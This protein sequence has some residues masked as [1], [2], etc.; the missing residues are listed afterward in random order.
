MAPHRAV[1]NNG[2]E[3]DRSRLKPAA[4]H[5][6]CFIASWALGGLYLSL[7]PS[8]AAEATGSPNLLWGGLVIF[9]LS[10]M[11][12]A[13]VFVFRSIGSASAMLAGC[14]SLFAGMAI[15]FG[16]IATT[17]AAAFLIGAAVAGVGFGLA[18]LG[19]FR[20]TLA[21]AKPDESA[22]LL[23]AIFIVAYLAFAVP[24]L[25]AGVA[26]TTYGLHSTALVY[27]ASLAGV[28][29][30]AASILL[31]RTVGKPARP[32]PAP[33]AVLPPGPCTC[34]P[35]LEAMNAAGAQPATTARSSH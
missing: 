27:S 17:T 35:C 7:G 4:T 29:A 8:L 23:A 15:T 11:G 25:I 28:A 34:P 14:L 18:F 31:L 3:A 2:I 30:A 1:R 9:L 16:A 6:R 33:S 20:M 5:A 19:G 21:T 13:A 22:G 26:T 12:A 10:G 32:A 24:A